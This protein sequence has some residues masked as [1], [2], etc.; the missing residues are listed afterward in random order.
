MTEK[1][2]NT[3][4]DNVINDLEI[5]KRI[6]AYPN[7]LGVS[8]R[9]RIGQAITEAIELLKQFEERGPNE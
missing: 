4:I 8:I 9:I 5:A 6:L 3:V 2:E 7:P 1:G